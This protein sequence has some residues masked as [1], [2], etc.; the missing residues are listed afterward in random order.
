[1]RVTVEDR[2]FLERFASGDMP[3]QAFRHADHV[4]LAWVL[5]AEAP[6]LPAL[7][8]FRASLKAFATR[9]GADGLYN[10]TITCFYVLLIADAMGKMGP[11][12][13]WQEFRAAQS[14]LF[15]Y[16]KA[17]LERYYPEGNAFSAAAQASFFLPDGAPGSAWPP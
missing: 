6:L 11:D 2:D 9:H 15:S 16:P 5:L 17:L 14:E 13:D 10:E 8:T 7:L 1:M 3:K 4:R 12:H